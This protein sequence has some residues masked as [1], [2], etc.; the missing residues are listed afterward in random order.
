MR[1]Q[2]NLK[3]IAAWWLSTMLTTISAAFIRPCASL[4]RWKLVFQ[5]TS[6]HLKNQWDSWDVGSCQGRLVRGALC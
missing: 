4:Q 2:R 1:S 6:G 5:I 3:T